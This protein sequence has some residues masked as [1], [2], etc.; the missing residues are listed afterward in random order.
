MEQYSNQQP[1]ANQKTNNSG[2][3]SNKIFSESLTKNILEELKERQIREES[4]PTNQKA[5]SEIV[6]QTI[7]QVLNL[8]SVTS[9]L[10]EVV[11][12]DN[13]RIKTPFILA[14]NTND[15]SNTEYEK[16]IIEIA[17]KDYPFM[18]P[19]ET[20]EWS[21][22]T[23][24]QLFRKTQN[25]FF[26]YTSGFRVNLPSD[27]YLFIHNLKQ[28]ISRIKSGYIV[29][30]KISNTNVYNAV[31]ETIKSNSNSSIKFLITKN[32]KVEEIQNNFRTLFKRFQNDYISKENLENLSYH[33]FVGDKKRY[34]L[35]Y[36][37]ELRKAKV[38][39]N[40]PSW[41]IFLDF[42]KIFILERSTPIL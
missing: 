36:E 20:L 19:N 27:E 32:D 10:N 28:L 42:C 33:F 39:F 34:R 16:R 25:D 14:S 3:N 21:Q 38:D 24:S 7:D 30:D 12:L 18:L 29:V 17:D 6:K 9:S 5:I 35:E 15:I 1:Q 13:D 37:S 4:I 8:H 40:N 22:I 26:Y 23:S 31:C 41:S 2:I 11:N